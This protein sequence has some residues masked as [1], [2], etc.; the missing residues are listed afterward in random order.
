MTTLKIAA[1]ALV[2]SLMSVAP[3]LD[4]SGFGASPSIAG[5]DPGGNWMCQLWPSLCHKHD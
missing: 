4:Q 2:L 5:T 1:A 3:A